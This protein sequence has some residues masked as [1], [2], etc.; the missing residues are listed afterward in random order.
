ME[1][2][3]RAADTDPNY[4]LAYAG[5]ADCYVVLGDYTG[6][7]NRETLPKSR[8]FAERALQYDPSLVEAQTTLAYGLALAW[9]WDRAEIEF[10]KAF[11][12][13]PNYP[14]THHWYSL[15]LVET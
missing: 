9:Q 10:K 7:A 11:E 12:L 6:A 5:L 15:T 8:A 3:Q 14:T 2:F 1:Q 4:A 13:N